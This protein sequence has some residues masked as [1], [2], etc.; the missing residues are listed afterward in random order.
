MQDVLFSQFYHIQIFKFLT[1]M[2]EEYKANW[3]NSCKKS[4]RQ[5][6]PKSFI[7]IFPCILIILNDM[8]FPYLLS[9]NAFFFFFLLPSHTHT[10]TQSAFL[11]GMHELNGSVTNGI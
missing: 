7:Y 6:L 4:Y 1:Q 11:P 2:M 9:S 8:H 3:N 10:H 5:N